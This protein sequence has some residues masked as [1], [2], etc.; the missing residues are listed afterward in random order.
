MQL[1]RQPASFRVS[2]ATAQVLSRAAL[3]PLP[4]SSNSQLTTA[5][6]TLSGCSP[7]LRSQKGVSA[8][9]SGSRDTGASLRSVKMSW[10]RAGGAGVQVGAARDW[11]AR[12]GLPL[13]ELAGQQPWPRT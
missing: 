3:P 13:M 1:C 5:A 9:P 2:F 4:H 12:G 11:L 6:S 8:T 7:V 10:A